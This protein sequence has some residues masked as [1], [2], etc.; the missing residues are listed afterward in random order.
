MGLGVGRQV[1]AQGLGQLLRLGQGDVGVVGQVEE[2][3]AQ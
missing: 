2:V 3:Q 1:R